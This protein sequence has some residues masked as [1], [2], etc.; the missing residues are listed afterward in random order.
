MSKLINVYKSIWLGPGED[1]KKIMKSGM[2]T[3]DMAIVNVADD[4]IEY[5]HPKDVVYIH[6]GLNDGPPDWSQP[7]GVDNP[8]IAYVNAVKSLIFCVENKNIVYV[9]CHGGVSRSP[10]VVICFIAWDRGVEYFE[11]KSFLFNI[12]NRCN[13]HP[14]HEQRH[15]LDGIFKELL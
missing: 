6:A 14:K 3:S 11:A 5:N 9:H 2:V 12:Y 4:F 13:P 1:V 7:Y 15:I 8:V 10:F